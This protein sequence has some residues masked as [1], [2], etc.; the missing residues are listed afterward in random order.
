MDKE[1]RCLVC[2]KDEQ[3]IPLME[4]SFKGEKYYICPQ[5]IPLLIHEPTK[6]VGMLPD[7][8]NMEAV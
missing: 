1:K 5:H 3:Q 6:L 8:E 4:M 2:K 7:A